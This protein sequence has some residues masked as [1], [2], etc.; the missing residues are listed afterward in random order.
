MNSV[1]LAKYK[2]KKKENTQPDELCFQRE[3][4]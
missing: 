3:M 4:I 1:K 2:H